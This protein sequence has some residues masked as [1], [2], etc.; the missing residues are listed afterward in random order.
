MLYG[1]NTA[2]A[3]GDTIDLMGPGGLYPYRGD[4]ET[5]A[6]RPGAGG[7]LTD[8]WTAVEEA[9]VTPYWQVESEAEGGV[10]WCGDHSFPACGNGGPIGGYGNLC[11]EV[12]EFRKAVPDAA[13]VRIQADLRYDT[14]PVNDYMFLS[15]IKENGGEYGSGAGGP[16]DGH[17]VAVVDYTFTYTAADLYDGTDIVI[18]FVFDS[19]GAW[20]DSD[21]LWPTTGAAV[22]DN[23]TATVNRT[24][25][26]ENFDD[27]NIGPDWVAHASNWG[28]N[29]ARVWSPAGDL[30]DCASN[31]SKLIAFIDDGKVAVSS[32]THG[33]PGNDY[34]PGGHIV[35]NWYTWGPS[36]RDTYL[37]SYTVHAA[38]GRQ[39]EDRPAPLKGQDTSFTASAS[40]T[41]RAMTRPPVWS[42][43]G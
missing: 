27:G 28:K 17:G 30:D 23:I 3:I 35:N 7:Y 10:A 25:Y 19:D 21:C 41:S 9:S 37:S 36:C 32:G 29:Y 38:W 31:Y 16:W 20:I 6:P 43:P 8:G 13:T 15:C 4:F 12:L 26:V 24:P 5:A 1:G 40:K 18:G 42:A 39:A 34:G 2:K 14:E 11:W 33:L 22:H